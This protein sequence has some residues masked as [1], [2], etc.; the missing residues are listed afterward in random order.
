MIFLLKFYMITFN[1]AL[2]YTLAK[3]LD[4]TYT[5]NIYVPCAKKNQLLLHNDHSVVHR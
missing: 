3:L 1:L 2:F 5:T 4:A